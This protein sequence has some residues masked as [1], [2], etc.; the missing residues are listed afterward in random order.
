MMAEIRDIEAIAI[1]AEATAGRFDELADDMLAH[2]MHPMLVAWVRDGCKVNR[3]GRGRPAGTYT[4]RDPRA[5]DAMIASLFRE[6]RPH[7]PKGA[8][9]TDLVQM[10]A[11]K[12]SIDERE[13][14]RIIKK[15][16]R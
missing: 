8:H 12:F 14:R 7:L 11:D 3:R 13:V 16:R 1:V 10:L 5:T 15:P 9:E 4:T 6:F 2:G